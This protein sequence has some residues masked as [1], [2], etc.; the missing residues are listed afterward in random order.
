[1]IDEGKILSRHEMRNENAWV[2]L[3]TIIAI[4]VFSTVIITLALTTSIFLT[5][6]ILSILCV[7]IAA[8]SLSALLYLRLYDNPLF[9][10]FLY[11]NG[12]RVFNH[13]NLEIYFIPFD[14]IQYIYKYH[15]GINPNGK[16]NAMAFRT[17]KSQPWNVII[18]NINNA[19][20]LINTIIHQQI[21]RIGVKSLSHGETLTFDII[22]KEECWLKRLI[23]HGEIKMGIGRINTHQMD[24]YSLSLSAHTLITIN[25]IINIENIF[26]IETLQK[27]FHDKIRLLDTQG[28]I[29]FSIDSSDLIN[30][31]LFIVLIEHMI[32]NRIPAYHA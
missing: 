29:I 28:D 25:G 18:N 10:Y 2:T 30:A 8:V 9:T 26:R 5:P 1:M 13:N 7:A 3:A 31:D 4:L 27:D 32:Q 24:T 19:Y 15:T 16:I 6:S 14:K 23:Y 20:L 17:S 22:K 11:E 21:M 12:V